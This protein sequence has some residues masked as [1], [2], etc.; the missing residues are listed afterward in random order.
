MKRPI[1][2]VTND[3]GILAP[4]IKT[5]VEVAKN[6]GEVVVVAPDSPQ[7][8]KGH[9]LT[10][11][12]PIYLR[13]V[14]PFGGIE[15][16]ECSGTPVDCVKIAKSVLFKDREAAL[17]VSGI[18]H[19]SN[20]SINIIYSGTVSA[21]ME[22]SLEGIPSIGFSLLDYNQD[23]DFSPAKPFVATLIKHVLEQGMEQGHLWNV[24]IPKLPAEAIK[25]F[26][27]CR[28]AEARWAEAFVE[29]V[30]AHGQK[31]YTLTGEF[32]CEDLKE[33]TD[34]WA[35]E[36]QYISIVPSMHDL[37]NHASIPQLKVLEALHP[38]E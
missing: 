23:A 36:H 9:A 5:L 10:I 12:E 11:L 22:A 30:D 37:T 34:I 21:A 14:D 26:K 38:E 3:D 16:Y 6:F 33:D 1:I 27:V 17:C 25:G 2:L 29:G 19:G 20:A 15:A 18:N 7:S 35:L 8:A 28:Q 13:K 4:G 31:N 32:K 24:N